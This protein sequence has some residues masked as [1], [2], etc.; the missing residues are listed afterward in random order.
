MTERCVENDGWTFK[1]LLEHVGTMISSVQT[2]IDG[3]DRRYL[4]LFQAAEK[5]TATAMVAAEK[6]IA[7]AMV[8]AEKAVNAALA[9]SEK[10]V[11]KAE[12]SQLR[13]NV[14]QNEFRQQLKDLTITFVTKDQLATLEQRIQTLERSD[15]LDRTNGRT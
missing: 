9:A 2:K 11:G 4:E 5:A 10:A 6:A 1:T 12:E 3:N 14:G 13:I 7:A 8:A 15:R